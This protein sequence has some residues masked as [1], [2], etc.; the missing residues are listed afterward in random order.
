EARQRLTGTL[1]TLQNRLTPHA[2]VS[3]AAQE[4]REKATEIFDEGIAAAKARPG[5]VAAIVAMVLAYLFRG[6]ILRTIGSMM[7]SRRATR[8][9][10]R[11]LTAKEIS[12]A[13]S[14]PPTALR[15]KKD[16]G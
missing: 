9:D 12:K 14:R 16:L 5:L 2:L 13:V 11:E 10:D 6:P 8:T 7:E 1:V 4:L 3:E 15:R